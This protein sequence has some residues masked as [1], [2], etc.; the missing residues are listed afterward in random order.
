MAELDGSQVVVV[1]L[2][3]SHPSMAGA[4]LDVDGGGL[5]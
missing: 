3:P 1:L 5:L 2:A 4:V